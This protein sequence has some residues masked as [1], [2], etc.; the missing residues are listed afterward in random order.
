MSVSCGQCNGCRLARSREMAVRCVHEDR[1]HGIP[2]SFVTLTYDEEHLPYDGSVSNEHHQKFIRALRD[3]L[4]PFKPAEYFVTD[5]ETGEVKEEAWPRYYM[6]GEY[7]ADEYGTIDGL[8]KFRIG[9]GRPHYHYL[10]F[11]YNF[12]DKK[13]WKSHRGHEYYR[14]P[15][16]EEIWTKGHSII[17]HVT[18]ET[19]A[20]TARYVMKKQT[21]EQSREHYERVL[22]TT[23]EVVSIEPEFCRM[24]LKPGIGA[25]W[26][27]KHGQQDIYDSGDFVS[28]NGKR[29]K[30]PRYYDKLYED[31]DERELLRVKSERRKQAYDRRNDSTPERL[32]TRAEC[33]DLRLKRLKRGFEQSD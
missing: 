16:L 17:G 1:M 25:R 31:L 3:R 29:Y 6:C 10:L 9:P 33:L 14:S 13:Y 27:E 4:R 15:F 32:A 22:P 19:A 5:K 12:P 2:G 28:I 11:G 18:P 23:G 26:F 8:R 20:Y 24:S 7:G 30:T 21:G